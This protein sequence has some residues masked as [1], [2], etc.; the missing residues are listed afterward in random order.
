MRIPS[1]AYAAGY[2]AY[3]AGLPLSANPY[4]DSPCARDNWND[5]WYDAKDDDFEMAGRRGEF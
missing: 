2:A 5:G 4:H 1:E 3:E